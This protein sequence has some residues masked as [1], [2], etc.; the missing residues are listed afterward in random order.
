MKPDE[1]ESVL[2]QL[3]DLRSDFAKAAAW[4]QARKYSPSNI[5]GARTNQNQQLQKDIGVIDEA[6]K[7][8]TEDKLL[9][10]PIEDLGQVFAWRMF[11]GAK[12][13][14]IGK[15]PVLGAWG[16]TRK[17]AARDYAMALKLGAILNKM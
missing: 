9:A 6:I 7:A 10:K 16:V 11:T 5:F 1:K 8:V 14:E 3:N 12:W 13:E 15:T 4:E 17:Y 2:S